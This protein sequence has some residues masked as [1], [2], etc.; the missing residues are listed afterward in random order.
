[1]PNSVSHP[2][3]CF[4]TDELQGLGLRSVGRGVRVDRSV[5][6]FGPE[7][8]S[9]GD[10]SRIDCFCVL[11]ASSARIE[12]GRYVH[13]GVGCCLFGAGGQIG[14]EDFSGVSARV[15]LYTASDDFGAGAMAHPTIPAEFRQVQSGPVVI[16]KHAIVGCG[17]V[18]LPG[19]EI[20]WGSAIGALSLVKN[21]TRECL[22]YGG[23]P[24][25][26]LGHQ[27]NRMEIE[28]QERRFEETLSHDRAD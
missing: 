28:V 8:I 2:S 21:S 7:H 24:A 27:R 5:R 18:V 16:R 20:G 17:S 4:S 10:G 26:P 14:F 15:C 9:I 6:F 11:S 13:L 1:V 22:I 23:V 3:H 25:R 19:V 12:I